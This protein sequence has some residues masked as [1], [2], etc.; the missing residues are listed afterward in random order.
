MFRYMKFMK[1]KKSRVMDQMRKMDKRGSGYIR[2]DEFVEHML[3]SKFK[4]N[5]REMQKV[6]A[7]KS[8]GFPTSISA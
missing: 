4:T 7:L 6:K 3:S 1:H 2:N 8:S 5:E